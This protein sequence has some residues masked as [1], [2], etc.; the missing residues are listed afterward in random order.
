M[1]D[2]QDSIP[3]TQ[4]EFSLLRATCWIPNSSQKIEI[5]KWTGDQTVRESYTQI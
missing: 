3:M 5:Q 2:T 1:L 4:K